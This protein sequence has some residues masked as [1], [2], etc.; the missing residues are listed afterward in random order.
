MYLPG[1]LDLLKMAIFAAKN[2]RQ[3]SENALLTACVLN[4]N[5]PR[6]LCLSRGRHPADRMSS[7][8]MKIDPARAKA[9]VSQLQAVHERIAAVAKDRPVRLLP[10][11]VEGLSSQA[12]S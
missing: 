1:C 9:L 2:G 11:L 10:M 6:C 3:N 5:R 7:T 8:E 12:C 4:I